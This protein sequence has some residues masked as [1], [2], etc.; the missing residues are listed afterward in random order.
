MKP[1]VVSR[2]KH[3]PQESEPR[4]PTDVSFLTWLRDRLVNVYHEP[5]DAAFVTRLEEIICYLEHRPI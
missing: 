2:Q 3:L 4:D 5:P 1:T